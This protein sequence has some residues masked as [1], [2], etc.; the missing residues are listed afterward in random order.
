MPDV[1]GASARWH[2]PAAAL[3]LAMYPFPAKGVA[4]RGKRRRR[5]AGGTLNARIPGKRRWYPPSLR[6]DAA[7]LLCRRTPKQ[8]GIHKEPENLSTSSEALPQ[9]DEACVVVPFV[10]CTNLTHL[11]KIR[12]P[13]GS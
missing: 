12:L 10:Q 4:A 6:F 5:G 8:S 7:A 13:Q 9:T 3:D 11:L 1:T 2:Q